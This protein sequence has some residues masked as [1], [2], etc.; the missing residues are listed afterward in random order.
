LLIEIL[1]EAKKRSALKARLYEVP[2]S[3]WSPSTRLTVEA[4]ASVDFNL[5]LAQQDSSK[6]HAAWLELMKSS[7]P[8]KFK[9]QCTVRLSALRATPAQREEWRTVLK[10]GLLEHPRGTDSE[11][12]RAELNRVEEALKAKP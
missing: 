2:E 1:L 6:V 9:E 11:I 10:A 12:I 7:T 8:P 5:S 4:L 3:E